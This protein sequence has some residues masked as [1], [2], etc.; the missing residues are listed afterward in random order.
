MYIKILNKGKIYIVLL[1]I[2]KCNFEKEMCRS[3]D[4]EFYFNIFLVYFIYELCED[5]E[6]IKKM[7]EDCLKIYYRNLI[8]V[9]D[10]YLFCRFVQ[11]KLFLKEVIVKIIVVYF[12]FLKIIYE[13]FKLFRK[14]IVFKYINCMFL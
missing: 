14:Y 13:S 10:Y 6:Y 3:I 8:V 7:G 1:N 2:Y 11:V 9:I 12:Y 4:I 5:I